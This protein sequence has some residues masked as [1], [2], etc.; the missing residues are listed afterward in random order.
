[1]PLRT[2]EEALNDYPGKDKPTQ[3]DLIEAFREVS[4]DDVGRYVVM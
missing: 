2:L 3:D 4:E 1:M